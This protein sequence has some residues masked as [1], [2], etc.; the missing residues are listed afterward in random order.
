MTTL[1]TRE[2]PSESM[3]CGSTGERKGGQM[4]KVFANAIA[5]SPGNDLSLY[6]HRLQDRLVISKDGKL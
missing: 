6:L 2:S 3:L 4:V 1:L 5:A